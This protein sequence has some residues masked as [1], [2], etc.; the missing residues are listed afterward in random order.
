MF[1]L[2]DRLNKTV[3]EIE[4]LTYNELIEWAAYIGM[5]QDG[6]RKS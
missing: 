2:A 5:M 1:A 6:A 4:E 3:A